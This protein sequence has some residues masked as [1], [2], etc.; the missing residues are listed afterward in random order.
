MTTHISLDG[1]VVTLAVAVALFYFLRR[2]WRSVAQARK[3]EGLCGPNCDC[4]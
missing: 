1:L 4:E 2:A 3:H